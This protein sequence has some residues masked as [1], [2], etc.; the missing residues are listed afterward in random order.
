MIHSFITCIN[1]KKKEQKKILWYLHIKKKCIVFFSEI[2]DLKMSKELRSC[3]HFGVCYS[4]GWALKPQ[5]AWFQIS[6][7]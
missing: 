6:L 4:P 3:N 5:K 1:E 2:C 7:F